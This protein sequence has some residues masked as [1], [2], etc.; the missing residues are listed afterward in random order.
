MHL[1]LQSR[2]SFITPLVLLG[3]SPG[4]PEYIKVPS[5]VHLHPPIEPLAVFSHLLSSRTF[6]TTF[7]LFYTYF[8]AFLSRTEQP[9]RS[10]EILMV[11]IARRSTD[12][13]HE[14]NDGDTD[15]IFP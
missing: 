4:G 1:T 6:G 10:K 12:H 14:Q 8:P 15:K 3:I 9:S 7:I 11:I 13:Y 5:L 2:L